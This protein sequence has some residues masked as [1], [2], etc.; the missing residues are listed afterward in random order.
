MVMIGLNCKPPHA[1]FPQVIVI[2]Y[3]MCQQLGITPLD[4]NLL[5]LISRFSSAKLKL[6]TEL[7]DHDTAQKH[8]A[9]GQFSQMGALFRLGLYTKQLG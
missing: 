9:A 5:N 2:I 8:R 4:Y 7:V 3:L 6:V 1:K